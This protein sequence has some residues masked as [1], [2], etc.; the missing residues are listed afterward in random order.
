M[1][2]YRL[3]IGWNTMF[4]LHQKQMGFIHTAIAGK[5]GSYFTINYLDEN[6]WSLIKNTPQAIINT[7]FR[8]HILESKSLLMLVAAI[9]NI[10]LMLLSILALMFYKKP[11]RETLPLLFT[12]MFFVF[13]LSLLIG[14]V[15]PVL[16]SIV[17][18]R[19]PV[20][21]F[22]LISLLLIIDKQRLLKNL[23]KFAK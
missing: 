11:N 7:L 4:F 12:S 18:L 1:N 3:N 13:I 16:G 10:G 23:G 6:V 9:E 20:V 8:P 19:L 5:A 22:Y 21:P 2:I 15:T 14:L 17:R